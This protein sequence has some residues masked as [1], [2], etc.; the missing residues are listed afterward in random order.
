MC[1][2]TF[3]QNAWD[4]GHKLTVHGWIFDIADGYVRDLGQSYSS[5]DDIDPIY[6]I[7]KAINKP[8]S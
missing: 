5:K 2:T 6:R 7:K 8:L 3:V 1:Y 4:R